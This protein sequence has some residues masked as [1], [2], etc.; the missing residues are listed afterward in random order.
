MAETLQDQIR[1]VLG[2]M[3][4]DNY[5]DLDAKITNTG[6]AGFSELRD[7]L[8]ASVSSELRPSAV[9]YLNVRLNALLMIQTFQ[10]EGHENQG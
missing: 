7:V 6:L 2:A 1:E 9:R 8:T 4:Y 10:G 5:R 3:G